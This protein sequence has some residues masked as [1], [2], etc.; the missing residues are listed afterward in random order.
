[1][2]AGG[3]VLG[4]EPEADRDA[5]A[6]E[7]LGR[8]RDHARDQVG[9]DDLG[10]DVALAVR[11]GRHGAVGHDYAGFAT[12]REL[13]QDV[14]DPGVVGVGR[15]WDAVPPA[16]VLDV[17]APGLDVEWRV[18]EDVV[19]LQVGMLVAGEGVAPAGAEA[20]VVDAVDGEVHLRHPP[21]LLDRLLAEDGDVLGIAVVLVDEP[22]GL[23]EHAA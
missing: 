15:R 12:G 4:E 11:L 21:G 22:L 3:L 6:A 19:H 14:L 9:L 8:Q 20:L 10:A 23:D 7:E 18:G 2:L 5:G 17:A 13:R 1:M 16:R